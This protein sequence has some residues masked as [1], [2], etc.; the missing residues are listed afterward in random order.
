MKKPCMGSNVISLSVS[1]RSAELP[2]WNTCDGPDLSPELR[3]RGLSDE[4]RSMAV[5]ALN[6]PF[7]PGCSFTTWIA[8]N[9]SP[10]PLIPEASRR[11]ASSRLR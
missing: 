1:L 8:W 3:I 11:R 5:F 7:E 6:P 2:I 10:S 9:L 4:M